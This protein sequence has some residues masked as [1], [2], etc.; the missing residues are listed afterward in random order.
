MTEIINI[1]LWNGLE[2]KARMVELNRIK[3]KENLLIKSK[4]RIYLCV[5]QNKSHQNNKRHGS[6][7]ISESIK[8]NI[9]VRYSYLKD[10]NKQQISNLAMK[11]SEPRKRFSI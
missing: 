2:I 10:K 5:N 6:K 11:N 7:P 8:I 1:D 4:E 3:N 9:V